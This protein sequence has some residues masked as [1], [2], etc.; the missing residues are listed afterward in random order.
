[1]ISINKIS[2]CIICFD[3]LIFSIIIDSGMFS[4]I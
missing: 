3:G 2:L 1:M 4:G